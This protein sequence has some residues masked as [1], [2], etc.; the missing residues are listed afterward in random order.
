MEVEPVLLDKLL[1][2]ELQ[3]LELQYLDMVLAMEL[4]D[5][6]LEDLHHQV[7]LED[8]HHQVVLEFSKHEVADLLCSCLLALF[9]TGA[10]AVETIMLLMKSIEQ[11]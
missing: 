9:S 6:V 5:L 10:V 4:M 11:W 7:V 8:L 3:M 1:E 2:A